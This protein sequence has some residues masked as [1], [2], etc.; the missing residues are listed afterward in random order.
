[1]HMRC[2]KIAIANR[3]CFWAGDTFAP[4]LRC[5]TPDGKDKPVQAF[6]QDA[7]L[8]MWAVL[9]RTVADL[10]GVVGFQV[11]RHRSPHEFT[12]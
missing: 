12:Y 5:K 11:H 9:G 7:F 3:T 6:L 1:M 4:K 10:P 8:D 2:V